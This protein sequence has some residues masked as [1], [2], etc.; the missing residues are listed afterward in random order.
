[1]NDLKFAVRQL[2]K[3]PGFA[4]VAVFTL[5]LGIGATTAIFSVTRTLLFDPL[6][7]SNPE[8]FV[9]LVAVQKKQGWSTPS[10]HSPTVLAVREQTNLFA[11]LGIYEYYN[12]Q[13][14]GQDFPETVTGLRVTPEFFSLWTMRP[15]LGRTFTPDEAVPGREHVI[16]LGHR[17]W[18][19][20][21]G[22]DPAIL[23]R[24]IHFTG[25]SFTVVGVMPPYFRFPTGRDDYW[26]PFA[27]PQPLARGADGSI[28]SI[29]SNIGAIA[30]IRPGVQWSQVQAFLDLLSQRLAGEYPFMAEFLVQARDLREIFVKPEVSR[31]L[32][33]LV[34]AAMLTL[35]IAC[36][37]VANLQLA[38]L[39]TRQHELAIRAAI[40]AGRWRLIRQLLTE[41]VLLACVGG[42]MGLIIT[43]F[44][45]E[46]L[47]KLIP[48]E[49]PRFKPISLSF[50][51][52]AVASTVSLATGILFGLAPAWSACRAFV[53]QTLKLGAA[54]TTTAAAPARFS[55]ALIVG[56]VA[57][58]LMLLSGAGLMARSVVALLSVNP[59][60]DPHNVVEVYPGIDLN[61]HGD[62]ERSD[63]YIIGVL[64]DLQQR[65]ASLPGI[66]AVG[67]CVSDYREWETF[68]T[69]GGAPVKVQS[70][71]IGTEAA[72]PLSVMRVPLR[73]GRWLNRNDATP[74]APAVLV[75]ES[76]AQRLW[77]GENPLGKK[78]WAR[79]LDRPGALDS[80]EVVGVV[81]DTRWGRYDEML[82]PTVFRASTPR[83]AGNGRFLV[84]RT[85]ARPVAVYQAIRR[86][87]KAAGADVVSPEFYS[88]DER[89][90]A[91]TAGHRILMSYL[92]SFA[93]VGLLLSVIGIYSVLAYSVARR[94]KEIGIRM[95]L[96]AAQREVMRLIIAQGMRLVGVGVAI[97]LVGASAGARALHSFL[98]GIGPNDPLT[99]IGVALLLGAVALFACCLP[100]RRA[101]RVDPMEALRHE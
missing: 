8:R 80:F 9:E 48:P 63:E 101:A 71:F 94:T 14:R 75:N 100:A 97:G 70:F 12:L 61:R 68:A 84:V 73:Q 33:A 51:V 60:F 11:R 34:G 58:A 78:I 3:R 30:Q 81:G 21:F 25:G 64:G 44:G 18:Q 40:G 56:Q 10:L 92:A 46:L 20:R 74:A 57:L 82:P 22:G 85:A 83:D 62:R 50:G 1:M 98:F 35:L 36:A 87:I 66:E 24:T 54:K 99:Y 77:P 90:Y 59:G 95:A 6:P 17:L 42:L 27:G 13:L 52:L 72:N 86:E 15:A 38:R 26:R 16:I 67:L 7:V 23:G 49:L 32:W 93:G 2:L 29:S 41:S 69:E 96:G 55:R 53:G 45:F 31:T 79:A 76:A 39:E 37:N 65:V 28:P 5:A 19:S 91:A 47:V 89:F 43:A 4:A 88:L